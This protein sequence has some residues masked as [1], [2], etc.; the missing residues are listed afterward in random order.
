MPSVKGCSDHRFRDQKMKHTEYFM[1]SRELPCSAGKRQ[2]P[3]VSHKRVKSLGT[4]QE[5]STFTFA[6][7]GTAGS[8]ACS[9]HLA[10]YAHIVFKELRPSLR[11]I[12][13]HYL[14]THMAHG[15]P[16]SRKIFIPPHLPCVGHRTTPGQM[17]RKPSLSCDVW[18]WDGSCTLSGLS[19]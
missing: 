17:C 5:L 2:S 4:T 19:W 14:P 12:C 1:Q 10:S 15:I 11:T 7:S 18:E 16:L 3:L 8:S 6:S 9:W 13:L